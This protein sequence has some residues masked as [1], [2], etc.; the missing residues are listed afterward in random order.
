MKSVLYVH[1]NSS[2][3]SA[4]DAID[5]TTGCSRGSGCD[6]RKAVLLVRSLKPAREFNSS[7]VAVTNFSLYS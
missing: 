1:R 6:L 7:L 2:V 4:H 3:K 5:A